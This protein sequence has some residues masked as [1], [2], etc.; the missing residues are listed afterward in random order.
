MSTTLTPEYYDKFFTSGLTSYTPQA[1]HYETAP[2]YKVAHPIQ[3]P[4]LGMTYEGGLILRPQEPGYLNGLQIY[5]PAIVVT[6]SVIDA[7]AVVRAWK[8]G[9][10][11]QYDSMRVPFTLYVGF[12][13]S[14]D[15]APNVWN[16]KDSVTRFVMSER[17]WQTVRLRHTSIGSTNFRMAFHNDGTNTDPFLILDSW[18]YE[19]VL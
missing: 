15:T 17:G 14:P 6:K 3:R 16:Q 12:D 10:V 7:W 18:G 11:K 4:D 1:I 2:G 19:V 13:S 8:S 5:T 9:H